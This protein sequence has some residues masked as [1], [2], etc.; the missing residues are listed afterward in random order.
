M[1]ERLRLLATEYPASRT[2]L[3]IVGFAN[4]GIDSEI[5]NYDPSDQLGGRNGFRRLID[6]A[7]HLGFRVMIH[8]NVLGMTYSHPRYLEFEQYQVVDVFGRRQGWAMDLDGDWLA[9]PYFAYINP[10]EPAW[11]KLMVSTLGPLIEDFDLD[12]VFLDQTLLAFNVERGPNFVTGMRRHIEALQ[13]AFPD[14][15]FAGEGLNDIVQPAL[16]LAQIHG[17]DSITGVHGIDS[18]QPWRR[19]HPV[20]ARLFGRSTQFAAHL[21]TKHPSHPLFDRQE[22]AYAEL[23]VMPAL[24]CYDHTQTLDHPAIHTMLDRARTIAATS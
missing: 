19:V 15:L 9:E 7:H 6:T 4:N 1:E 12:A 24:V 23:G 17:L 3:Y 5:P 2:L 20:S 11:S 21:L 16:P 10:G 8:T 22:Q 13:A 14:I 18:T